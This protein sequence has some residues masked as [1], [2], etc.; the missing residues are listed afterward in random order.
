MSKEEYKDN[1]VDLALHIA[2]TAHRGQTDKSGKPYICHPVTLASQLDDPVEIAVALLHDTIEDTDIDATELRRR[3]IPE[4]VILAVVY[5][6]R[7]KDKET[8]FEYIDTIANSD[9]MTV[10]KIKLLDLKHNMDLSRLKVVD[11]K[12][13]SLQ[14]RYLKAWEKI[15]KTMAI[16]TY[17]NLNITK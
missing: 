4:E 15:V 11:N 3:G 13:K 9:N 2:Y 8:Y 16:E 10:K 14:K 5:L 7:D 12:A 1:L 6:T 17:R